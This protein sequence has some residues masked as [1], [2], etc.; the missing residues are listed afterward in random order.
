MEVEQR[1]ERLSSCLSPMDPAESAP[2]M[3]LP[4]GSLLD[5][6]AGLIYIL[7]CS[8]EGVGGRKEQLAEKPR[9]EHT[10]HFL[11]QLQTVSSSASRTSAGWWTGFPPLS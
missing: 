9:S 4:R 2:R 10:V 1:A 3:V 6:R 5:L 8:P 11:P 7:M